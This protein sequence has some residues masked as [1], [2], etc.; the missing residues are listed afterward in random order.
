M[1]ALR[2]ETITPRPGIITL[3]VAGQLVGTWVG[4]LEQEHLLLAA[5]TA[6]RI[7]LDLSQVR[8]VSNAGAELLRRLARNGTLI[9]NCPSLIGEIL[10]E[11]SGG[12]E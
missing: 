5:D 11:A 1:A 6:T 12:N 4:V 8:Y 3:Q 10:E 7:E 2:I 9:V